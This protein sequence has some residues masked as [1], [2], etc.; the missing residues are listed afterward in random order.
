MAIVSL[1]PRLRARLIV[2]PFYSIQPTHMK[3]LMGIICVSAEEDKQC[4]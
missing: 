3:R 1:S 2:L 4:R